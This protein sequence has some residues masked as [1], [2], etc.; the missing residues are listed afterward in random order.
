M[1]MNRENPSGFLFENINSFIFILKV[2]EMAKAYGIAMTIYYNFAFVCCLPSACNTLMCS[3]R[4]TDVF[5]E[6][7]PILLFMMPAMCL[8]K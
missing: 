1:I 2:K 6:W 4:R 7:K 8:L 3:E 5:V